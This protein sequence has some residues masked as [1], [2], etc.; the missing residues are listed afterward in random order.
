[1]FQHN[2]NNA[3]IRTFLIKTLIT[4]S[5]RIIEVKI[6]EFLMEHPDRDKKDVLNITFF[7]I[8][9]CFFY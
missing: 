2:T 6:E 7:S 3:F 1:M 5:C 4:Y 9:L 8:L